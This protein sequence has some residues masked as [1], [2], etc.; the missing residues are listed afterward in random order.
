[1]GTIVDNAED[2]LAEITSPSGRQIDALT[3]ETPSSCKAG[4]APHDVAI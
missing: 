1:M 2:H 3:V 4:F